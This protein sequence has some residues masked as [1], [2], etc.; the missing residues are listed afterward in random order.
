M[1]PKAVFGPLLA[2]EQKALIGAFGDDP[3][4][5]GFARGL[6]LLDALV[7]H[8]EHTA[9]LLARLARALDDDLVSVGVSRYAERA[10]DA[11]DVLI[12]MAEDNG[13]GGVV[14]ECDGD[15]RRFGFA[16]RRIDDRG[17][18]GDARRRSVLWLQIASL[19][20]FLSGFRI[21]PHTTKVPIYDAGETTRPRNE[22]G[23]TA[24]ISTS[25][26]APISN[27]GP[28]ANTDCIWGDRPM[29]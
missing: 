11:R 27:S 24:T 22:C 20:W 26:S 1:T 19:R 15:F 18:G 28:S 25:A 21:I 5:V 3:L 12:V 9:R 17:S 10:L 6:A 29:T 2:R 14:R 8:L 7:Q 16:K 13:G 4:N 23:S